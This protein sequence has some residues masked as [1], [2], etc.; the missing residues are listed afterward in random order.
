MQLLREN[1]H[2][3]S[4]SLDSKLITMFPFH[5]NCPSIDYIVMLVNAASGIFRLV[6]SGKFVDSLFS[7]CFRMV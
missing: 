3:H 6:Q 5:S 7:R 4:V 2:I 1:A